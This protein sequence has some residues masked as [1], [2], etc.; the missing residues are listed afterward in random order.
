MGAEYQINTGQCILL[1][2][3]PG[4]LRKLR[5]MSFYCLK[6]HRDLYAQVGDCDLPQV[7]CV[8]VIG[9]PP[10]MTTLTW[11]IAN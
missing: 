7:D 2:V 9:S 8:T 1:S 4:V 6:M 11:F 10:A 5:M 3:L